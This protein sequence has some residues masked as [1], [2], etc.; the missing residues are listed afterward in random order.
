MEEKGSVGE[1]K[2]LVASYLPQ[3]VERKSA[4][5]AAPGAVGTLKKKKKNTVTLKVSLSW[6]SPSGRSFL[7]L[8]NIF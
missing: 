7:I 2:P 6:S 3:P 8:I 1:E 5:E 4:K